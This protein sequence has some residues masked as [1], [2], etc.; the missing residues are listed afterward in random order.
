MFG[1]VVRFELKDEASAKAFDG[2]VSETAPK[3]QSDEP[4]TLLYLVH[5]VEGAPLSRV[6]YELYRDREAFDAHE[7]Q[8]HV[9]H[10]LSERAQYLDSYGVELVSPTG[11]K[12][13]IKSE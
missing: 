3:I 6:F 2:L 4:G 13:L 11:G 1:L 10:F 9:K 8:E 12:G 5:E 7:S